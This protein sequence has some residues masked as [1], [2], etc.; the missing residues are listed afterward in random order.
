MRGGAA[1]QIHL[2]QSLSFPTVNKA[3][4]VNVGV[5]FLAGECWDW[6][7]GFQVR[8]ISHLSLEA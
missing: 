3:G 1:A 5:F 2:G 4:P 7:G 6:G 8:S